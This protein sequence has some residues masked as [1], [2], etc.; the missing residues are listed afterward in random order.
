M[1]TIIKLVAVGVATC[2]ASRA[3]GDIIFNVDF[4]DPP[5]TAGAQAANGSPPDYVTTGGF[6]IT[7]VPEFGSQGAS[8]TASGSGNSMLFDSGTTYASGVHSISWD[9]I[10]YSYSSYPFGIDSIVDIESSQLNLAH[11]NGQVV[12]GQTGAPASPYASTYSTGIVYQYSLLIDLDGDSYDFSINGSAVLSGASLSNS[13]SISSVAF[14][15]PWGSDH[16][17][18]NFRWEIVPEPSTLVLISLGILGVCGRRRRSAA[19]ANMQQN[20]RA[21]KAMKWGMR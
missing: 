10:Q 1:N 4:E 21:R 18:D 8:T 15:N 5:H 2:I 14:N 9:W 20:T 13:A 6:G 19:A 12:L 11:D 7:Y 17:V 16:A 3:W